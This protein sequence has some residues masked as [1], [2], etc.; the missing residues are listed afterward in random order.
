MVSEGM[1]PPSGGVMTGLSRL[2]EAAVSK[3]AARLSQEELR[4]LAKATWDDPVLF[5]KYFLDDLFPGEIPWL[6]RGI[7][8]ILTKRCDFLVKYGELE[9]II[10]NFVYERDGQTWP[11]FEFRQG[12]LQMNLNR[13]TMLM[14]PRGFGK[15]TLA[16]IGWSV[17]NIVFGELDFA[18]YVSETAGH[19]QRQLGNVQRILEGNEKILRFFGELKPR[20]QDPQKWRQDEFETTTGMT[21][22]A[23]GRGGQIRGLNHQGKRPK[24]ILVDDVE[25]KESVGTSEQRQK[26]RS[27]AYGDLQPALPALDPTATIVAIGTLLHPDSLLMTWA[28]DPEW[29]VVKFGSRDRQGDLIWPANMDEKKLKSREN[30]AIVSNTLMEYYMEFHS[31]VRTGESQNFRADMF[32]YGAMPMGTLKVTSLYVDP[33]ISKKER[34]DRCTFTVASIAQ[35]KGHIYVHESTGRVGVTVR[36]QVDKIFELHAKYKPDFVGIEANAY[37]AAL[38]HLVQEEMFRRKTYFEITP[39][40]NVTKKEERIKGILQPRFAARYIWFEGKFIELESQLLH[41]PHST[42]DDD[43]DGLAGAVSLLD[44]GAFLAQD[45][46]PAAKTPP[47]EEVIGGRW[48]RAI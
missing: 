9:K 34:A 38:I 33:A 45:D 12:R 26:T 43:A 36:E 4:L 40:T 1:T 21:M 8:A 23:R 11:I 46:G 10:S 17:Y 6:H 15:T 42:K 44:P 2:L 37:Q 29:T 19:A 13:Y 18:V 25:D 20:M 31:E 14:V 24:I 16:G 41:F 22:V 32:Q 28:A 47:L 3:P 35:G 30:S 7:L 48:R 5:C 39:V 27:W